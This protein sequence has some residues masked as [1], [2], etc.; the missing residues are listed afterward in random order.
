MNAVV[1]I[2]GLVSFMLALDVFAFSSLLHDMLQTG[3]VK[4]EKATSFLILYVTHC[5]AF[6]GTC[7]A[8]W[9]SRYR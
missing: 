9:Q 6:V 5:V 3:G 8:T 1:L 4:G 2:L 7:Y